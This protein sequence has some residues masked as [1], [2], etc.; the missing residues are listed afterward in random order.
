MLLL[1]QLVYNNLSHFDKGSIKGLIF[2]YITFFKLKKISKIFNLIRLFFDV[3]SSVLGS[4]L[5]LLIFFVIFLSFFFCSFTIS[6]PGRSQ[7]VSND[8][9]LSMIMVNCFCGM[10]GLWLASRLS[11][12]QKGPSLGNL[13]TVTT[14]LAKTEMNSRLLKQQS[15]AFIHVILPIFDP[16]VI[17]ISCV[18]FLINKNFSL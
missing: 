14:Q 16:K 6:L 13:T 10:V 5:N 1:F 7:E 11:Y 8:C 15:V 12:F 9:V 18:F 17:E 3:T 4:L 2:N